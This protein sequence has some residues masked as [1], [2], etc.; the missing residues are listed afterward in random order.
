M[1]RAVMG[2]IDHGRQALR[3]AAE[4][5]EQAGATLTAACAGTARAEG[6]AAAAARFRQVAAHAD[7]NEGLTR[8]LE[9]AATTLHAMMVALGVA[10]T[11]EDSDR[12]PGPRGNEPGV[13]PPAPR[14]GP[15]TARRV[16]AL[17]RRLPPPVRPGTGQKT[18]GQLV[19]GDGP[20]ETVV[21]GT[22]TDTQ[23]VHDA[24]RDQGYPLPG[25]PVVATHVEMKVAARMRREGITDATLVV[26]HIPRRLT[27]GGENLLG[28]VLPEGSRLTAH[29]TNGYHQTFTGGKRPPW[30]R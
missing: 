27:W 9:A 23:A 29:G 2:R 26:N 25:P 24:L 21:S 18:H 10:S 28:M 4:A 1:L 3:A 13:E 7:G 22:D 11:D 5:A 15:D 30:Q 17:R 19:T 20:A 8:V 12:S 6:G 16:E 14:P